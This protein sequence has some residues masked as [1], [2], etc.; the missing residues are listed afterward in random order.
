MADEVADEMAAIPTLCHMLNFYL[1]GTQL[2]LVYYDREQTISS[3][4]LDIADPDFGQQTHIY[5]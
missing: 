2:W 4:P 1:S 5:P 3:Q